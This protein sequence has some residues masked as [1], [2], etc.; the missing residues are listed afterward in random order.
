[1]QDAIAVFEYHGWEDHL[2]KCCM[3]PKMFTTE[4]RDNPD[5]WHK[6]WVDDKCAHLCKR[7]VDVTWKET[8]KEVWSE[9]EGSWVDKTDFNASKSEEKHIYELNLHQSIRAARKMKV[10]G[11]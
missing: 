11:G 9:R 3:C 7:C 8:M 1:M 5:Q 10:G 4:R 6:V 2:P